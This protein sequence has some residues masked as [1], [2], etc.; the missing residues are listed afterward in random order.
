MITFSHRCYPFVPTKD[1]SYQ[2]KAK[3]RNALLRFA[4]AIM[5]REQKLNESLQ[6]EKKNWPHPHMQ[7]ANFSLMKVEGMEMLAMLL[8]DMTKAWLRR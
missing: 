3:T 5:T 1:A 7:S 2:I 8:K 4:V 6:K